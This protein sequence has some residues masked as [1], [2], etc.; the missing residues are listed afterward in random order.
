[1]KVW[2]NYN[3]E[4]TNTISQANKIHG[5]NLR[6]RQQKIGI[7]KA[8]CKLKMAKKTELFAKSDCSISGYI[9]IIFSNIT[10]TVN[11]AY[12]FK[13]TEAQRMANLYQKVYNF[14]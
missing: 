14:Y 8:C 9:Y 11:S 6:E 5:E 13:N 10:K 4:N 2:F 3:N 12:H 7:R 1:M